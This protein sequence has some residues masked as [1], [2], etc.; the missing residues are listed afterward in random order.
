MSLARRSFLFS[1]LALTGLAVTGCGFRLRGHVNLPFSS[2]Y[3]SINHNTRMGA[4]IIR[5]IR[6]GSSTQ[7]V[8]D[9]K[10]A[11]AIL[12][13]VSSQRNREVLSLN[14]K[15]EAREYE[16][17][18]A[19]TFRVSDRDGAEILPATQ[20]VASREITYNEDEYLSRDAEE[21]H[22]YQEMERDLVIQ[23]LNRLSGMRI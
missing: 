19:L 15:G 18:L 1:G 11:E 8:Q 6:S 21:E 10:K 23:L 14:A 7:I 2:L 13:L 4:Q 20:F 16:L 17:S 9:P 3:L 5:T 22:F 12:D